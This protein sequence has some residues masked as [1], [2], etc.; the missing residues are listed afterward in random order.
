MI[1][2]KFNYNGADYLL[3]IAPEETDWWTCI[4]DFDI[5]YCEDYNQISVYH[6]DNNYITIH[7]QPIYEKQTNQ[8]KTIGE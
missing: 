2:I 8:A 4:D 5:H 6:K 1:E 7:K 3:S